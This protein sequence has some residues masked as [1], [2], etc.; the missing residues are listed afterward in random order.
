MPKRMIICLAV[1]D[2]LEVVGGAGGDLAED[3]LL[4]GAA[5]ERHREGVEQLAPVVRNLS[6]VGSEIV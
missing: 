6:S 2:L 4:G 3:D 5:A 1:G